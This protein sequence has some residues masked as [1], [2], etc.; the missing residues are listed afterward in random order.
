[1][2]PDIDEIGG[3]LP[4]RRR[5]VVIRNA[6][7]DI[8]IRQQPEDFR[9]VPARVPKLEAVPS[10]LRQQ[11]EE[12]CQPF[13]V[14]LELRRQLKQDRAGL[15]AQKRQTVLKQFEAVDRAIREALPVSNEFRCLPGE[16]EIIARLVAPAFHSLRRWRSIEH[17]VQFRGRQLACVILK[18]VFER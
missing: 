3:A 8:L 11:L 16:Y 14:G 9:R 12:R 15:L 5:V 7:R 18:L 1:M 4:W 17:A 13:G 10:S 2:A 6:K